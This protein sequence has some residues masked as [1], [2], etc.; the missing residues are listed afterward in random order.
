MFKFLDLLST[1]IGYP[2]K[3]GS[4]KIV[5]I[6][7]SRLGKTFVRDVVIYGHELKVCNRTQSPVNTNSSNDFFLIS[8]TLN[9][10]IRRQ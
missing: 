9:I 6:A 10:G 4:E 7:R 3:K 5:V 8:L 1:L 2:Q